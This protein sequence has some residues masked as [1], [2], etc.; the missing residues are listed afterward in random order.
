MYKGKSESMKRGAGGRD[1]YISS[2]DL[3]AEVQKYT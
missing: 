1:A 3:Y 2:S